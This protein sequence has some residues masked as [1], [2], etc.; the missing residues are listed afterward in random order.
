MVKKDDIKEFEEIRLRLE[1]VFLDV[2][3]ETKDFPKYTTQLMNIA[4]QNAQGTRPEVVGKMS[5]LIK[6]CPEKTFKAW[7]N[8]YLENYPDAI[9]K[10]TKKVTDM[11]EKMRQAME[12][13]D[14]EMIRDWVEDL[15]I[16][17]TAEGLIIQEIILKYLSD[18]MGT[19]WRA[20]TSEEES[21]NID[22][23]IGDHPVQIKPISYLS[24]KSSVRENIEIP[25]IY[26]KKTSKYLYIYRRLNSQE[27]LTCF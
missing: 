20:A 27:Q 24:K 5:E 15:V 12:L 22:G 16:T 11:V 1:E 8:W 6:K 9:D 23:Y 18:E 2:T 13:I 14:E 10:A 21:R 25:I 19:S 4:N 17:K 26:Y 7:T 3:G